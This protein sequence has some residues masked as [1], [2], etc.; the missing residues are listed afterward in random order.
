MKSASISPASPRNRSVTSAVLRGATSFLSFHA[1]GM[2]TLFAAQLLLVRVLGPEQFGKY[3][4]PLTCINLLVM[5]AKLGMDT[6][7]LRLLA[8]YRSRDQWSLFRGYVRRSQQLTVGFSLLLAGITAVLGLGLGRWL[9]AEL[10][11]AFVLASLLL[12]MKVYIELKLSSFRAL[13]LMALSKAPQ[14]VA[15]PLLLIAGVLAIDAFSERPPTASMALIVHGAAS[16]LTVVF[17]AVIWHSVVPGG[18]PRGA[19]RV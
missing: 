16:L 14:S 18:S 15:M 10:G 1:I 9:D 2:G 3:I 12:P 17:S 19:A 8:A 4:F 5:V 6:A 13:K 7:S 11:R